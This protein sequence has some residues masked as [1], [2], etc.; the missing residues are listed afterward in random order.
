MDKKTAL[1]NIRDL[2]IKK[3]GGN[4]NIVES[5]HGT[6]T[7]YSVTNGAEEVCEITLSTGDYKIAFYEGDRWFGDSFNKCKKAISVLFLRSNVK[8]MGKLMLSYGVLAMWEKNPNISY[9]V[10]DDDSDNSVYKKNNIYTAL[11]FTP[12]NKARD[13]SKEEGPDR[14]GLNGPE[15]QCLLSDFL[16]NVE[17]IARSFEHPELPELE[18]G[19]YIKRRVS[20]R[21]KDKQCLECKGKCPEPEY[22]GSESARESN[23]S[24]RSSRL[25]GKSLRSSRL[26]GKSLRR[27]SRLSGKSL[28]R[29]TMNKSRNSERKSIIIEFE[30]EL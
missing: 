15:K 10:L 25:S 19:I 1:K 20:N 27:S 22:K 21:I 29:S 2:I 5:E 8:G 6:I 3:G 17:K 13:T 14:V 11:S 26:S 16:Y 7:K 23:K 24:V 30:K 18:P 28:R 12:T 4:Y 9:C